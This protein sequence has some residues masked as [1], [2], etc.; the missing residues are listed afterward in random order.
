MVENYHFTIKLVLPT[1]SYEIISEHIEPYTISSTPSLNKRQLSYYALHDL[2]EKIR[3]KLN[4]TKDYHTVSITVY[5]DLN[6]YII[7]NNIQRSIKYKLPRNVSAKSK[8][9]IRK[10]A[11]L[12]YNI[13]ISSISFQCEPNN[14]ILFKFLGNTNDHDNPYIQ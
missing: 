14:E 11:Y 6:L 10:M 1:K 2:I 8:T 3:K 13:E 9:M 12:I 4:E 5:N 7:L